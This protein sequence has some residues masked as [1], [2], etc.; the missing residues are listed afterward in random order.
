MADRQNTPD[1]LPNAY[2]YETTLGSLDRLDMLD[3]SYG[4]RMDRIL[5]F[6]LLAVAAK[7][8]SKRC[9]S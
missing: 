2:V 4:Y 6:L 7:D 1:R 9:H 8:S 5:L 3:G